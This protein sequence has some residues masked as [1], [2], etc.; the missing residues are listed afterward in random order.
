[1]LSYPLLL[2]GILSLP[3]N[4]KDSLCS[5]TNSISHILEQFA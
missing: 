3:A 4:Q 5:A 2:T 1:M